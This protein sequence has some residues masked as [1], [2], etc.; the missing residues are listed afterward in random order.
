M[1]MKTALFPNR[2][3]GLEYTDNIVIPSQDPA[4]SQVFLDHRYDSARLLEM[5]DASSYCKM[6]HKSVGP[7]LNLV[8]SGEDLEDVDGFCY[9]GN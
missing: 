5:Y 2:G 6:L 9:S 3:T 7:K 4:R 1:I 8:L